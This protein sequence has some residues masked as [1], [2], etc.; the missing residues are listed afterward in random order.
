MKSS[1][2]C[3]GLAIVLPVAAWAG[4]EQIIKQR[5]K[6]IRDQNNAKQ[7]VPPPASS[8]HP[9]AS[10]SQPVVLAPTPEQAST[11]RL[12]ASIEPMIAGANVTTEQR[13][14]LS[15]DLMAAVP[16]P[17]KPSKE[18]VARL[19][20]ELIRGLVAKPVS[21]SQRERL[22][23]ALVSSL[24]N[25]AKLS[26]PQLDAAARDMQAIFHSAGLPNQDAGKISD[27]LRSVV[28]DAQ[29]TK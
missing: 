1:G 28:G 25:A 11:K 16:A 24:G 10:Q 17:A 15:S 20:D 5:A 2:L 27:A 21:G 4:S 22:V 26:P 13:Q 14:K 9:A 29:K 7:G 12:S 3:L 6:D 23:A 8:A 18:S 19:S